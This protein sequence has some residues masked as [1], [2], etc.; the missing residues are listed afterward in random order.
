V[1]ALDGV[2]GSAAR[3]YFGA[4]MSF[5]RSAFEWP[6]RLKHPAPDP[7]NA[8]LSLTYTLLTN[9]LHAL[10]AAAGLDP[11]FGFLHQLDYG[12]PSLALDLVEAFRHPL[13]DRFVLAAINQNLFQPDDFYKDLEHGGLCLK[14]EPLRRYFDAFEKTMI[15]TKQDGAR[16]PWRSVLRAEVELLARHF[17]HGETWTPFRYAA[18]EPVPESVAA[19]QQAPPAGEPPCNT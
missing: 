19:P 4:L 2:E 14:P 3:A 6:G 16:P 12:R 9:E 11:Y 17:R 7:I 13:A 15:E 10:L 5:N 1:Q 18:E 8:L